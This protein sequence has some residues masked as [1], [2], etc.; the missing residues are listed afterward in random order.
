MPAGDTPAETIDF[1]RS[2][3]AR[4]DLPVD[5]REEDGLVARAGHGAQHRVQAGEAVVVDGWQPRSR[6]TG[7]GLSA[8][9]RPR[10]RWCWERLPPFHRRLYRRAEWHRAGQRSCWDCWRLRQPGKFRWNP[11]PAKKKKSLSSI[12]GAAD[13]AAILLAHVGGFEVLRDEGTAG[14][15]L[16]VLR[17]V[18]ALPRPSCV[19][20]GEITFAVELIA[21][22][23]R[24]GVDD[25]AGRTAILR[26][27]SSTC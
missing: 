8:G 22:T 6:L 18:K 2:V 26:R 16:H 17:V 1:K 14:R 23:L 7:R 3:V 19:T 24:D 9:C 15:Q 5:L 10:R 21:A 12:D 11:S 20:I 27:S 13:G 25:A 4:V